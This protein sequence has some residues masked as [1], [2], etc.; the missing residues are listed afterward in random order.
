MSVHQ[1]CL[2]FLFYLCVFNFFFLF[3]SPYPFTN[4]QF[5]YWNGVCSCRTVYSDTVEVSHPTNTWKT[6][7]NDL[8]IY[9]GV[10]LNS[11]S[12][13]MMT[14]MRFH[15]PCIWKQTQ[16]F[17]FI[18][19]NGTLILGCHGDPSCRKVWSYKGWCVMGQPG[20]FRN[21]SM[22]WAHLWR[23]CSLPLGVIVPKS[24][25]T[26]LEGACEIVLN[27]WE[28]NGWNIYACF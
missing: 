11:S 27:E 21:I 17:I 1:S 3:N 24:V 13:V 5:L 22:E 20:V 18:K 23:A 4:G 8:T 12:M 16:I 9:D 28:V 15:L 25:A 6:S 19:Y 26:H 14:M 2:T 7:P 10:G